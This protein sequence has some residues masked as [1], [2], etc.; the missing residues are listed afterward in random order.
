MVKLTL[1]G[2]NLT[3]E[4]SQFEMDE[5]GATKSDDV[6]H[7]TASTRNPK[8]ENRKQK[9]KTRNPRPETRD[10]RPETRNLEP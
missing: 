9:P 2:Q 8:T 10:P 3:M 5:R 6:Y 1:S 4:C 7:F